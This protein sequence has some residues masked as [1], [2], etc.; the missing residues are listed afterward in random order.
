MHA[1]LVKSRIWSQIWAG[2]TRLAPAGLVCLGRTK[3]FLDIGADDPEPDVAVE[4]LASV[5]EHEAWTALDPHRLRVLVV[6]SER[7]IGLAVADQHLDAPDIDTDFARRGALDVPAADIAP[8]AEE[9][10]A[11]AS[12]Q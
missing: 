6:R 7:R 12:Q 11:Q 2:R 9:R 10:P 5:I 1:V 3:Q 4:L 8:I